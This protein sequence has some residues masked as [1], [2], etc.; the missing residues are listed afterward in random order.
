MSTGKTN[1]NLLIKEQIIYNANLC[2][3][4]LQGLTLRTQGETL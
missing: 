1:L 2:E 3:F 4:S